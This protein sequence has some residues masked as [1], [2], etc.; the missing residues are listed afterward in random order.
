LAEQ[1]KQEPRVS[2][3]FSDVDRAN[4]GFSQDEYGVE[5]I[6][7]GIQTIVDIAAFIDARLAAGTSNLY[8]EAIEE[9][10]R[11]LFVKTLEATG[12][13]QSKAAEILGITRGKVRDRIA[14]FRIQLD[15][16]VSFD[17]RS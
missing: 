11:Y 6:S 7:T 15:R 5:D 3:D 4:S 8:S 16:A 17:S 10:E 14:H 12:G 13:N 2:G 1:E 9:I